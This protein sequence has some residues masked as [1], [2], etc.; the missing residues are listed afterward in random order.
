MNVLHGHD[1]IRCVGYDVYGIMCCI[2][3]KFVLVRDCTSHRL[4]LLWLLVS[5]LCVP[6]QTLVDQTC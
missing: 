3:F 2:R 6:M 5:W 1:T 4:L